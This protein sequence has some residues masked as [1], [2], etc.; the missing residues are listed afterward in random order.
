MP[1]RRPWSFSRAALIGALLLASLVAAGVLAWQAV[2]AADAHRAGARSVVR[3]YAALVADEAIRRVA[4]DVGYAD[5]T[6]L[7]ALAQAAGQPAG[8]T[9]DAVAALRTGANER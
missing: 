9:A 5:Y 7:A 3:D 8:L 1:G 6:V 4:T 2:A